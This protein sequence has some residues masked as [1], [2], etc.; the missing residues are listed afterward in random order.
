MA[1]FLDLD[2]LSL[3]WDQIKDKFATL[4]NVNAIKNKVIPIQS[5]GFN[6]NLQITQ[7]INGSN[8]IDT[9]FEQ[10]FVDC[11]QIILKAGS[12]K[13]NITSFFET[14]DYKGFIA[15]D[16]KINNNNFTC[17]KIIFLYS[18]AENITYSF[19]QKELKEEISELQTKVN[20]LELK[21]TSFEP[22]TNPEIDDICMN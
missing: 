1:K 20:N 21:I 8:L 13:Y 5:Y 11:R 2:G 7:H 19:Y 15:Q 17:G 9:V 18:N 14:N 16:I 6:E 22:I 3:V 4:E 10:Y 12:Y